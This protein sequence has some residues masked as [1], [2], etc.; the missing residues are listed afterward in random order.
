MRPAGDDEGLKESSFSDVAMFAPEI[1]WGQSLFAF[2]GPVE[3]GNAAKAAGGGDVSDGSLCIDEQPGG[4]SEPDI[5]QEV[6]EVDAGLCLE[7]AA[8]GGLCHTYELGC[9]GQAHRPVEIGI[10]KIDELFHA[11]AVHINVV[12]VVDLFSRQGPG[13]FGYGEL[14]KDGHELQHRV[15]AGLEFELFEQGGYL[16][17]RPAGEKD[18]FQGLF[19]E[20]ANST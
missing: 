11:P 13:A 10:H 16:L 14:V 19:E 8:E 1:F 5:I 7:K 20:V 12:G 2:E 17:D 6:D 3:I 15:E 9:F 18:P 4:M